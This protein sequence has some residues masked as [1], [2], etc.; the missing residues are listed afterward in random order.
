MGRQRPHQHQDPRFWFFFLFELLFLAAAQNIRLD[1]ELGL[2]L[3]HFKC[4]EDAS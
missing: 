3:V 4:A 1:E 2:L